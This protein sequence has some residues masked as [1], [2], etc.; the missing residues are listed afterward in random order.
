MIHKGST[1]WGPSNQ[2]F[3]ARDLTQQCVSGVYAEILIGCTGTRCCF[4]LIPAVLTVRSQ[5]S[6]EGLWTLGAGLLSA[7]PVVAGPPGLTFGWDFPRLSFVLWKF[8]GWMLSHH[9]FRLTSALPAVGTLLCSGVSVTQTD[10]FICQNC[11]CFSIASIWIYVPK[12]TCFLT[13]LFIWKSLKMEK[14][15]MQLCIHLYIM[16][17]N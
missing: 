10:G 2:I 17:L 1:C 11:Y 3:Q 5:I 16:V 12:T 6:R 4:I 14:S 7:P 9:P 15:S 8:D 13:S